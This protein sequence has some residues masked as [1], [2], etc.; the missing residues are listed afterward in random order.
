MEETIAQPQSTK[1]ASIV[2][3]KLVKEAVRMADW[4][5]HFRARATTQSATKSLETKCLNVR[6]RASAGT[7]L[8]AVRIV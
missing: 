1:H 2:R 4:E 7:P 3:S 6:N 5:A 8:F